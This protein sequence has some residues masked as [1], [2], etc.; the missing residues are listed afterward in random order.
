[1]A[2]LSACLIWARTSIGT[3]GPQSRERKWP[4]GARPTSLPFP[5]LVSGVLLVVAGLVVAVLHAAGVLGAGNG[6]T[7]EGS[8]GPGPSTLSP[9]G[10]PRST[11][12]ALRPGTA[13]DWQLVGTPTTANLERS[14]SP[15][16]M[17]DLDLFDSVGSTL[18]RIRQHRSGDCCS[19]RE[20]PTW[21]AP[22]GPSQPPPVCSA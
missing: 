19:P 15:N 8:T 7:L 13:W 14:T 22:L 21:S 3:V 9:A 4:S 10:S 18:V 11:I 16:K 6:A 2:E 1:M 17:I 20:A 12:V 5:L